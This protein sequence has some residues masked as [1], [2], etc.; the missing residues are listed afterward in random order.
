[1]SRWSS[2]GGLKER[3][4]QMRINPAALIHMPATGLHAMSGLCLLSA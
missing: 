4:R 3:E 1:M 2:Q